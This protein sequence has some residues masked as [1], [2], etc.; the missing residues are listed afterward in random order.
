MV[1]K[2]TKSFVWCCGTIA[3]CL[4]THHCH[5]WVL[6]FSCLLWLWGL[7]SFASAILGS[8][9][10]TFFSGALPSSEAFLFFSCQ[11][12]FPPF[13]CSILP[14]IFL[15]ILLLESCT[16]LPPLPV[17]CYLPHNHLWQGATVLCSLL[18]CFAHSVFFLHP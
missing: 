16:S 15:R 10:F 6:F 4:V 14:D 12:C 9:L 7:G 13:L 18:W 5:C 17:A 2:R 1:L 11:Y 3:A 8:L